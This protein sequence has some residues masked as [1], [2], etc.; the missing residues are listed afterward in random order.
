MWGEHAIDFAIS[1]VE[2]AKLQHRNLILVC[3]NCAYP[4]QEVCR[5][6]GVLEVYGLDVSIYYAAH[7]WYI[8]G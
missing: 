2:V 4:L 6:Q 3:L 1:K 5:N 7:R 8:G